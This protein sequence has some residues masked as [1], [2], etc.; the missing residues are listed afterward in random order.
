M[1]AMAGLDAERLSATVP[2]G[3]VLGAIAPHVAADLG[4]RAGAVAVTGGHDHCCGVAGVRRHRR[5]DA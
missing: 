5:R 3:T 4:W 2:S 1:L